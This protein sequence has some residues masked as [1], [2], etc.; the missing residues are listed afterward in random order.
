MVST[1]VPSPLELYGSRP[2]FSMS[3]LLLKTSIVGCREYTL[4][5]HVGTI[6]AIVYKPRP[7][8]LLCVIL[9]P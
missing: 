5:E 6:A 3:F 1:L 8:V 7:I 2:D 4:T 9:Y